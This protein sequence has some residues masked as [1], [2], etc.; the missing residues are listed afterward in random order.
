MT[1]SWR[2]FYLWILKINDGFKTHATVIRM[3]LASTTI[4]SIQCVST[5]RPTRPSIRQLSVSCSTAIQSTVHS[6]TRVLLTQSRASSACYRA[7]S[8]VR[9]W[10]MSVDRWPTALF[11]RPNTTDLTSTRPTRSATT[12]KTT[13]TREDTVISMSTMDVGVSHPS[14][15]TALMLTLLPQIRGN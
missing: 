2:N 6:D 4:T 11:S 5:T 12:F 9:M 8:F 10:K 14:F 1:L 7:T 13:S 15:R 3:Y